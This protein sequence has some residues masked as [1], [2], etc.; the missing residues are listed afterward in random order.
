MVIQQARRGGASGWS[1]ADVA[2]V[3]TSEKRSD[4]YSLEKME[5]YLNDAYARQDGPE[6]LF[7]YLSNWEL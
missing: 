7:P 4:E 2:D 5:E 3:R 1:L 6:V